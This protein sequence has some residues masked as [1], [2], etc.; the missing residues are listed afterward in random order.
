M[1][2]K[3]EEHEHISVEELV[4]SQVYAIQA[5]INVLERKG[6]LT[7]ED[8]FKEIQAIEEVVGGCNCSEDHIK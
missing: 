6:I 2:H 8:I 4:L 5:V 3:N 7:K 1:E